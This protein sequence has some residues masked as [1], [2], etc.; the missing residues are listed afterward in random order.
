MTWPPQLAEREGG[1]VFFKFLPP[2]DLLGHA[3][4]VCRAWYELQLISTLW[5]DVFQREFSKIS[6]VFG[7]HAGWGP[8]GHAIDWYVCYS[9]CVRHRLGEGIPCPGCEGDISD[10]LVALYAY[11]LEQR[12]PSEEAQE[13]AE[14]L[15]AQSLRFAAEVAG[16]RL[17]IRMDQA[18]SWIIEE[19]RLSNLSLL[20]PDAFEQIVSNTCKEF[21]QLRRS[22]VAVDTLADDAFLCFE[23]FLD[24]W[25]QLLAGDDLV[26]PWAI[27]MRNLRPWGMAATHNLIRVL[28]GQMPSCIVGDPPPYGVQLLRAPPQLQQL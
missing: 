17:A 4:S 5:E 14:H 7:S 26:S 11:L 13:E 3:L 21:L 16:G 28:C 12:H 27:A 2:R 25:R 10:D 22:Q 1:L 19:Y 8:T 15:H 24:Y 23:D 9:K 6:D 18:A 20:A